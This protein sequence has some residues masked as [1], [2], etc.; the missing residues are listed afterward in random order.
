MPVPVPVL[1]CKDHEVCW[2]YPFCFAPLTRRAAELA[3][4]A[5][6]MKIKSN[7]ARISATLGVLVLILA[8]AISAV[9]L[10]RGGDAFMIGLGLLLVATSMELFRRAHPPAS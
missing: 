8:L 3:A 9:A 1:S 6:E 5:T 4:V 10:E 7:P 2:R